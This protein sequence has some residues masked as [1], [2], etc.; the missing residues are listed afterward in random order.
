M[1]FGNLK[2]TEVWTIMIQFCGTHRP[3]WENNDIVGH[4]KWCRPGKCHHSLHRSHLSLFWENS[5]FFKELMPTWKMSQS[6]SLLPAFTFLVLSAAFS[7]ISSRCYPRFTYL[8]K[9]L[10]N[11]AAKAEI[12]PIIWSKIVNGRGGTLIQNLTHYW[13]LMG[14]IIA[15]KQNLQQSRV[16]SLS[17]CCPA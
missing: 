5:L 11:Y 15:T 12:W 2:P 16:G 7:I 10:D 1:T 8:A 6:S 9:D 14:R 4:K 17:S 13:R 3:A